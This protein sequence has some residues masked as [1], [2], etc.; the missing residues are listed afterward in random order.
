MRVLAGFDAGQTHTTCRL[1]PAE[2]PGRPLA[3]GRGPGVRHLAEAHGDAL[4]QAALTES[5]R[6]ARRQLPSGHQA[7]TVWA[8]GVGASGIE[9]G[10]RVQ[11][12]GLSLAAA[13]LQLPAKRLV[14]TG[15]ERTALRGA[16]PSGPGLVVISGTGMICLGRDG[17]G[18]EAR[19]GGWGWLLDEAGA[20]SSIGQ[21]ALACSLLMADGR[22]PETVLRT[23]LWARLGARSP[24]E[25]KA[26]VVQ[27]GFGAAGFAALAPAVETLAGEEDPH[28][29]AIISR[30]AQALAGSLAAVAE[31]LDLSGPLIHGCGGAWRNLTTLRQSTQAQL[32]QRLPDARWLEQAGDACDGALQMAFQAGA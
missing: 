24:Q 12:R 8:A 3:E 14:V 15:D 20:A 32:A 16:F 7:A 30:S 10:S 11:S 2:D 31:R 18:R 28:A 21:Q 26:L 5:L 6:D 1:S 9:Q 13:A 25:I 22:L 4:F 17:Q 29:A 19:C 23:R 27:E